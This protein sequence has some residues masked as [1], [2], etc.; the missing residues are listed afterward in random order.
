VTVRA[1]DPQ[2]LDAVVAPVTVDVIEVGDAALQHCSFEAL[3]LDTASFGR[4][5][6]DEQFADVR[7]RRSFFVTPVR[8]FGAK[9]DV[10]MP[11][12]LIRRLMWV[13]WP[14]TTSRPR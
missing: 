4:L 8:P 5:L 11:R 9:C 14:P 10:S 7:R 13:W 2:I 1:E 6:L 3:A 12:A